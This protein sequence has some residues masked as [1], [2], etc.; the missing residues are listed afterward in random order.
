MPDAVRNFVRDGISLA[1]GKPNALVSGHPFVQ[2][3]ASELELFAESARKV[4]FSV[5]GV[6]G[7]DGLLDIYIVRPDDRPIP[8]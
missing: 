3:L 4:P 8:G 7:E 1:S 6:G 5:Y 2:W